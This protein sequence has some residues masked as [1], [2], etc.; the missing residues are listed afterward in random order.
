MNT[1]DIKRLD[2]TRSEN[3]YRGNSF[4]LLDGST[5]IDWGNRITYGLVVFIVVLYGL[6]FLVDHWKAL[7]FLELG[8]CFAYCL[9][10]GAYLAIT[11]NR[12]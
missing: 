7:H 2:H 8:V 3:E 11:P 12:C 5:A 4:V 1:D 9:V 6:G 10:G